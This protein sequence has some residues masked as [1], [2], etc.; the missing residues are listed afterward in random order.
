MAEYRGFEIFDIVVFFL[1]RKKLLSMVF[2]GSLV[3]S[4]AGIYLFVEEQYEASA[5]IIPSEDDG[6]SGLSG[7]LKGLKNI[8][9]NIGKSSSLKSET[10]RYNT[11]IFSRTM[12]EEIITEFDLY[13]EYD[14][15]TTQIDY[16]EKMLKRLRSEISSKD[17]DEEAYV[18]VARSNTPQRAADIV[19]FIIRRLNDKIIE[20]KVSKSKENRVFLEKRLN[21]IYSDLHSSEDSLRNF[22][23]RSGLLELKSQLPEMMSVYG[24]LETDLMTRQLKKSVL[25]NLYDKQSPEVKNLEVEIR[26]YEKKLASLRSHRDGGSMVL[27]MKTLPKTAL[28]YYRRFRQVEISSALLEFIV[29]MYEQAKIEEK[30]DYPILQVI[31][32]AVPPAKKTYPPRLI[33]ALLGAL[34]VTFTYALGITMRSILRQSTN[35][36]VM[37]IR[38]EIDALFRKPIV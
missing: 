17:T 2:F 13:R 6:A 4:Y 22:Q 37:F 28:E 19:N 26:E 12:L 24:A 10:N 32:F 34:F 36:K 16:R 15:D 21:E 1:Q 7:M 30:K 27:A 38:Q 29:P 14:I 31:D 3:L 23:E 9:L 8:P 18:I 35:P 20:L 11:I 33:F 25:E 5:I